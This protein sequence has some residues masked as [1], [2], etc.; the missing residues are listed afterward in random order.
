MLWKGSEMEE[1]RSRRREKEEKRE[2]RR[3]ERKGASD[4]VS[5]RCVHR[6]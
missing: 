3:R 5:S 4:T 1:V 2:E 6:R